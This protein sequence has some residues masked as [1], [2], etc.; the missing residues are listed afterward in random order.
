M[1]QKIVTAVVSLISLTVVIAAVWEA[2]SHAAST[3]DVDLYVSARPNAQE[4]FWK[5]AEAPDAVYYRDIRHAGPQGPGSDWTASWEYVEVKHA[6]LRDVSVWL[7]MFD[8][9]GSVTGIVRIQCDGKTLDKPF[10]F[11]VN[12][13]NQGAD[14][15]LT[16][17]RQ[18]AYW[19]EIKLGDLFPDVSRTGLTE[20]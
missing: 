13:G 11:T 9:K 4:V 15:S 7:N 6:R 19:Q 1:S 3:A 16:Q 2:P 12:R 5:R 20:R 8:T 17:R 10:Q 18:S 14:S